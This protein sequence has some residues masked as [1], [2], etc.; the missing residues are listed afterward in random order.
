MYK[1][2]RKIQHQSY[3]DNDRHS[4]F[5]LPK[6]FQNAGNAKTRAEDYSFHIFVR[7]SMLASSM[8]RN[9]IGKIQ[10]SPAKL[11]EINNLL[12]H[13][14][15]I[16][17]VPYERMVNSLFKVHFL[18]KRTIT[19][20][21]KQDFFLEKLERKSDIDHELFSTYNKRYE[22]REFL[23]MY[24]KRKRLPSFEKRNQIVNMVKSNQVVL[25]S[26]ETGCGK[27]TQVPQ[28]LLDEYIS[29]YQGSL[30]KI[31]CTQPRRISAISVA[32]RVAAERGE[33]L[34]ISVGYQIR[35]DRILPR[36]YGSILFVTTGIIIRLMESDPS[37]NTI[38]HLIIDEIHE[39]DIHSDFLLTLVKQLIV[40]RTDLKVI[41]MSATLNEKQFKEYF[42]NCCHVEIKGLSHHVEDYYL[43]DILNRLNYFFP[44][45]ASRTESMERNTMIFQTKVKPYIRDVL[46]GR[47]PDAV[48][49]EL[50]KPHS[51]ELNIDLIFKLA[52]DISRNEREGSILIFVTGY[53]DINKLFNRF[54]DL[55]EDDFFVVALHSEIEMEN[56]IRVFE[57]SPPGVRKIIIS[58]NIAETSITIDDVVYV[59][60]SGWAKIKVYDPKTNTEN[61]QPRFI[62][63]ANAIQRK[64]RAGRLR[65]GKCFH[66]YTK[67]RFENFYEFQRPEILRCRLESLMLQMKFLQLGK[68][69]RFFNKMIDRPDIT[70]VAA[71]LKLLNALG[72]L[73]EE[74]SLTPLGFYLA[75]LP[76]APQLGKMLLLG[77]FFN[78]L[79]PIMNISVC[80]DYKSPFNL[81]LRRNNQSRELDPRIIEFAEGIKSDHLLL[82]KAVFLHQKFDKRTR[83]QYCEKYN[84]NSTVL[85][86]LKKLKVEFMENL[87]SL[88]L[89][90]TTDSNFK[91]LNTNSTNIELVKSIVSAG[92][93]PNLLLACTISGQPKVL[94][95][96]LDDTKVVLHKKSILS[97][98]RF[99]SCPLLAYYNKLKTNLDMVFDVTVC[100][101]LPVIFFGDK[102]RI[103]KTMHDNYI[104]VNKLR[105]TCDKNTS[106]IIEQ[107]RAHLEHYILFRLT[108][109]GLMLPDNT[110]KFLKIMVDILASPEV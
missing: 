22:D 75:K 78:C 108:Q 93:Y 59:I 48:C 65:E 76:I 1:W 80:L 60:D 8:E 102:F 33:D 52:V 15:P 97:C 62:S 87:L 7:S 51:E 39:R 29:S 92:L 90:Q 38:S 32:E 55:P 89:V 45:S 105:F 31:I 69:T 47:Y 91:E 64:G 71:S 99:F 3:Q 6:V 46:E 61:L 25:I 10:I 16:E 53:D 57:P 56:Q 82:H 68:V 26:G 11:I 4:D 83:Q 2:K 96:T 70:T 109:P 13:L 85:D 73:D 21:Q 24:E 103:E 14:P 18:E 66:L 63:K 20:D 72:A 100:S 94:F 77:V 95:K 107:L 37:L 67:A 43:E 49:R 9:S 50:K 36:K 110:D 104:N 44:S 84:I 106:N 27:T 17:D 5:K 41:L 40:K 12:K 88:E 54:Y 98:D 101:P 28:F 58:T 86:M 79:E 23:A 74:E 34:G 19:L 42:D 81:V 30:C 35:L